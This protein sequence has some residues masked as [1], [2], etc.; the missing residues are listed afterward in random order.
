MTDSLELVS[1]PSDD[2][3]GTS[4][5]PSTPVASRAPRRRRRLKNKVARVNR[6]AVDT[7]LPVRFPA[8]ELAE[9]LSNTVSQWRLQDVQWASTPTWDPLG[10][11][12]EALGSA[13]A[14]IAAAGSMN[15]TILTAGTA[16]DQVLTTVTDFQRQVG[17]NLAAVAT[18][19]SLIAAP[20][21]GIQS[22]LATAMLWE[23]VKEGKPPATAGD[24]REA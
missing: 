24:R 20:E 9:Q 13:V 16:V 1:S 14:K 8:L 6:F 23:R 19:S 17:A 7:L 11:Q 3:D 5:T 21:W 2:G 15:T 18:P 22:T 12:R 10:E 4:P